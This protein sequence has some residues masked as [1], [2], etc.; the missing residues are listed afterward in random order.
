LPGRYGN[1][2]CFDARRFDLPFLDNR[3][4]NIMTNLIISEIKIIQP[5]FLTGCC[6]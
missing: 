5:A 6:C 3:E 2:C 1:Q 4:E